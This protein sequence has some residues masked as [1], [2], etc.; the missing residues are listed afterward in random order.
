M[1]IALATEAL[2]KEQ[3]IEALLAAS[4]SQERRAC[5]EAHAHH[6][7]PTTVYALK[8]YADRIERDDARQA[9]TI[10]QIASEL[11]EACHDD[12]AH[13]CAAW[14]KANAHD[15]LAAYDIAVQEYEQAVRLFT[16]AG[17]PLE[18]ARTCIGQVGTL[19]YLGEYTQ[20]IALAESARQV[21]ETHADARSLATI[22]L[23]L[24]N[25]HARLEQHEPAMACFRRALETYQALGEMR[26]VAIAQVNLATS[27]RAVDDYRQAE[28]LYAQARPVFAQAGLQ[29]MLAVVEHNLAHLQY[30]RG[31]YAE[32]LQTFENVRRLFRQLAIPMEIA[33]VELYESDIYL[34]L[35]IPEEALVL[36]QQAEETFTEIGMN[37]ERARACSNRAVALARLQRDEQSDRLLREARQLFLAE[38]NHAWAAQVD[39]QA[40]EMLAQHGKFTPACELAR[41]SIAT[42]Q[43]LAA[44]SK[45]AYAH[46]ILANLLA[47]QHQWEAAIHELQ[48][49]ENALV[50]I[51]AAWLMQRIEAGYGRAYEG[52]GNPGEAIWHYQFAVERMEQMVA[53]LAAEEHRTAFLADKLASYEALV[54][55]TAANDAETAYTW[56][57]RAKSRALVDLLAAGVRPQLRVADEVDAQRASQLQA[58]REE[59][60]WLYTRIT[61]GSD[62]DAAPLSLAGPEIW[63]KI[64]QS[65]REV[66]TL[67]RALQAKHAEHL[68]LQR[69]AAFDAAHIRRRL[70]ENSAL[71]EYFIARG[72]VIA[73]VVTC[74]GVRAFP[75]LAD[76]QQVLPLLEQ[77]T[78]QWGKFHFGAAYIQHHH[79]TLLEQTNEVLGQ[80]HQLLFAPLQP[81]LESAT[82]LVIVPHGPLHALPFHA[83]LADGAYLGDR[84]VISYA[85]SAAVWDFCQQKPARPIATPLFVGIP[86]ERAARV[87]TEVRNLAQAFDDAT[88]LIGDQA[89]FEQICA[90]LP[91]KGIFHLAAHGIFRPTTPLLSGIRLADRWMTVQDVYNL[92]LDASLVTLGACETG[93][94]QVLAGDD[95]VG[96]T[97]GFLYAG[98]AALVVSL[99]MVDDEAM[100]TLM[101][102]FYQYLR[103]GQPVAQALQAASQ[104][105]RQSHPHPYYWAPLILV[106]RADF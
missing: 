96:L 33:Y 65:E 52:L 53:S 100:T 17:L 30:A 55:L 83:L 89:T 71:V 78:F 101:T 49:A 50:G 81:A 48:Q 27:L 73:F 31:N 47:D 57:E 12:A 104:A 67:W 37:F 21:F 28:A 103:Q 4:D 51:S 62:L 20:A 8:S 5:I 69:V 77:L 97:R 35:N 54:A 105:L 90:A 39:L 102:G 38:G 60:N 58:L 26:D 40:A 13:A 25:I 32:A 99:W 80:L 15:S 45:A 1:A 82:S 91:G 19:M 42:Y 84:Y 74:Q 6:A 64:Q 92:E 23:N 75:A 76:S 34:D 43:E 3:F 98:A 16:Q 59:L 2:S 93:L 36:A 85:P 68:S 106:G 63:R 86:D 46:I 95:L 61:R 14:I 9:Y 72:Q 29:A 44:P 66:T 79:T 94:G 10:G 7:N 24:G 88:L 70:A 87:E 18:A 56:A 22:N 11:A 41:Q